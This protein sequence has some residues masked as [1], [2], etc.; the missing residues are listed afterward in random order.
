MSFVG[1]KW[2]KNCIPNER[3]KIVLNA[4]LCCEVSIESWTLRPITNFHGIMIQNIENDSCTETCKLSLEAM[5]VL[6]C[7]K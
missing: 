4:Q 5:T 7:T 3:T 1:I 2:L 6:E